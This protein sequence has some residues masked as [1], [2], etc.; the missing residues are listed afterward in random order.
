MLR[1]YVRCERVSECFRKFAFPDLDVAL[2]I[3]KHRYHST[4]NLIWIWSGVTSFG[5][6]SQFFFISKEFFLLKSLDHESNYRYQCICFKMF[7]LIL[8][9]LWYRKRANVVRKWK[10]EWTS[11]S[12]SNF[13]W[14]KAVETGIWF[15]CLISLL[16]TQN[17]S[18]DRVMRFGIAWMVNFVQFSIQGP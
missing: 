7:D 17:Y 13:K 16:R 9:Q 6:R 14:K 10:K 1:F 18:F 11:T 4:N 5:Q 8:A 15:I 3:R 2:T 12:N